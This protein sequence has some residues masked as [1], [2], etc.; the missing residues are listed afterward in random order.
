MPIGTELEHIHQQGSAVA[1]TPGLPAIGELEESAY[2]NQP[3]LLH[4]PSLYH[5]NS[6]RI[7]H[8]QPD[9][10]PLLVVQ[11]LDLV[12]KTRTEEYLM[13]QPH[14]PQEQ[15][16]KHAISPSSLVGLRP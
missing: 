11:E 4:L 8:G 16:W 2:H 9:Y 3:K 12:P 7:T 15:N 14:R 6:K 5:M 1:P 13:R 10:L